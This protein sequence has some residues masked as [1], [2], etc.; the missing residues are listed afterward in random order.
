[1]GYRYAVLGAGQG[2]ATAYDLAR[3]GDAEYVLLVDRDG[4]KAGRVALR[5]N[6]L[7]GRTAIV[8]VTLDALDREAL[9]RRLLCMHAI[10]GAVSYK[11]NLPLTTLAIDLGAHYVDLGGNTAVVL[12]QHR[13]DAAARA[14]GVSIV[15]DCGMG[16]GFN[17]SL[18]HAL[19]SVLEAGVTGIKI[20]CGGLPERPSGELRYALYFSLEGLVNEYSGFAD[21][22]R[23]GVLTRQATLEGIETKTVPGVGTLEAAYTSGALSTA[24]WTFPELFP[25]LKTL[26]YKTLRYPGHWEKVAAWKEN[27]T[28]GDELRSR[29]GETLSA[30]PDL[31]IIVVEG[32]DVKGVCATITV[33]DRHDP[34]TG[35]SA[36]QRLTGFHA[37][38]MAIAAA[39][40]EIPHGVVAVETVSGVR[41]LNEMKQRDVLA[42][43]MIDVS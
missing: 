14:R 5:L 31:G 38:T 15:P 32:T 13:Y 26:E 8:P 17:L 41:V 39:R 18:A 28:L 19:A 6:G 27:G 43:I 40:G 22:L 42:T 24:P 33:V 23:D 11:L 9:M 35:F 21:I 36:M 10:V 34:A 3:H 4:E 20:Y 1:M 29:L 30:E 7:L 12:E 2:A 16:P 37:S 25:T